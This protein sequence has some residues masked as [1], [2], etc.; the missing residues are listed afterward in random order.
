MN[1]EVDSCMKFLGELF[2][3]FINADNWKIEHVIGLLSLILIVVGGIFAL[4]QWIST[5]RIKRAEFINQIIEK[6]RFDPEMSETMQMIDYDSMWYKESFHNSSN[7]DENRVDRLLSYL[8]Y[9]CYIKDIGFLHKK[10]FAILEYELCRICTSP[11]VCAY[12]WN[13]YHFSK[14]NN[15]KCS[16]QYL[17][18][19]GIK[20]K[21]LDKSTFMDPT[22][23][24]Y[25]KY[26]NF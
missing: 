14:N 23:C 10:E 21:L 9:I 12:L 22:T 16:F 3:I 18:D 11:S 2:R 19:Y 24:V 13:L 1:R 26:L 17:I 20:K 6:L 25:P 7:D 8:T 4:V 5:N 15:T